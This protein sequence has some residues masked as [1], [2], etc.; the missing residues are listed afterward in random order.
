MKQ[1]LLILVLLLRPVGALAAEATEGV[2]PLTVQAA[3]SVRQVP[4]D[5]LSVFVQDLDSGEV[6][7]S[8]NDS[9]ARN[10]G[11]TI[12]LLTTL[13]AL[14]VLGPAYTWKTD[15]FVL[16]DVVNGRLDGDLLLKGYGDPFLVT[17]RVW[18][19]LRNIRQ[20]GIREINGDLHIDDSHFYLPEFDPAEFDS[21]PLRAYNV[22]PNALLMNFKV[23]RYWF[24]PEHDYRACSA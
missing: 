9:V 4:D 5:S 8:W 11:S 22:A 6:V 12:K 2:L 13:V 3:L 14:D 19:L 17:E 24:E 23:V 20:L 15:V 21:Q 7:L 18:Q 1:L 10:P 16:G